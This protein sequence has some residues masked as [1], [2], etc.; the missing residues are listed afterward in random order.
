MPLQTY[1]DGALFGE[2]HGTRSPRVLALHGWGRDRSDFALSLSGLDAISLDLPGFGA[3]PVP[4]SAWGAAQYSAAL[5]PV[6]SEFANP[7]VVVG[8][9]FGGRVATVLASD[10]P[11]MVGGLVLVGVPLLHRDDRAKTKPSTV[12][13]IV[14]RLHACGLISDARLE[15]EKRKRGS[16]DYRAATGVMRDILVRAIAESYEEELMKVA[17]QVQLVWG[18]RDDEVPVSV[19]ERAHNLLTDASLDV[20]ADVGHDVPL[21]APERIRAAI[22]GL[23]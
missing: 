20:V 12:Y 10:A 17:C 8:H 5:G 21:E 3:S 2:R 19:A 6:L 15:Q 13:R 23:L 9:S 16:A 7:P 14:K 22:D 11:E 1:G 4:D 18:A